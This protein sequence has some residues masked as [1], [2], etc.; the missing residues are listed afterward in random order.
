M[1]AL[2]FIVISVIPTFTGVASEKALHF[3]LIERQS[4][5]IAVGIFIIFVEL[6]AFTA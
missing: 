5:A 4:T 2:I 1:Y 6:T 3:V